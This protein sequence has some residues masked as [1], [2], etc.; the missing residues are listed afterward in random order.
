MASASRTETFDCSLA[1]FF[2]VIAD[3]ESYPQFIPEVAQITV[4]ETQGQR[5]LVEFHVNMI[6]S[7]RYKIWLTATPPGRVEWTWHSGDV[8][9]SQSGSWSLKEKDGKTEATYS[10]DASFGLLVPGAVT[11]KLVEV[12]LPIMMKAYHQRVRELFPQA[13]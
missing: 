11:K 13:N 10:I 9:K 12:N 1:Q 5:K 8:F 6:K 4:L 7:I 3:Y 2:S